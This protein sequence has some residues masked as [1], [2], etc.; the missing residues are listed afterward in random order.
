MSSVATLPLRVIA[1]V[2]WY[3]GQVFS[4]SAALLHDVLTPGRQ[5]TPRVVKFRLQSTTDT[6]VTAIA[7]LIT[8]TPGTLTLGTLEGTDERV[9]L[10]H[11]MYDP[12][13]ETCLAALRDMEARM[14]NA[15]TRKGGYRS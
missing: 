6:Q 11:S 1:F 14:L 8:L 12:D 5:A 2:F 7:A 9:L 15:M 13:H 10:V 4:S 3:V